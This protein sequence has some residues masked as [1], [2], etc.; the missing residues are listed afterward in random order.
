MSHTVTS[1]GTLR[2]APSMR[3]Q[4]LQE[5]SRRSRSRTGAQLADSSVPRSSHAGGLKDSARALANLT[6]IQLARACDECRVGAT[7]G[8][9]ESGG[10]KHRPCERHYREED[11]LRRFP[12]ALLPR[13]RPRDALSASR[14]CLHSRPSPTPDPA[15]DISRLSIIPSPFPSPSTFLLPLPYLPLPSHLSPLFL[16][17]VAFNLRV[18]V[19]LDELGQRATKQFV[20][21]KACT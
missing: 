6:Q 18:P 14:A 12:P 19:S 7:Q 16:C 3:Q 4:R 9:E 20:A 8:R 2:L 1:T 11:S 17:T 21:I 15:T 13:W 10:A 5:V